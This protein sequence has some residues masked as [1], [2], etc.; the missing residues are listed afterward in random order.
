MIKFSKFHGLGND[1]IIIDDRENNIDSYSQLALSI[2]NRNLGVGADGLII[3]KNSDS[4]DIKMKIYNR[5][6]SEAPMC[7]NGIRCFAKY[8][9]DNNIIR[10]KNFIVETLNKPV[11]I[12]IINNNGREAIILVDMG[13]AHY[14]GKGIPIGDEKGFLNKD[15]II[16]DKLFKISTI[17]LGN[18][19]SVLFVDSLDEINIDEIGPIIEKHD[20]FPEKTNV[21]FCEIMDKR[22]IKLITWE[23]GVGRTLACGTG[24]SASGLI[25]SLL[26]GIEKELTIHNAVGNIN[27]NIIDDSVYMIG[28][29]KIICEGKFYA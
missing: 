25:G 23:R 12:K 19:H 10:K 14:K 5:D 15:I 2:C 13:K 29:S 18:I 8:V 20:L 17:D 4:Y 22:N 26:Y 24:A 9:F 16:R 7:G 28:P 21:N 1:F 27:I 3:V 11:G 6:G